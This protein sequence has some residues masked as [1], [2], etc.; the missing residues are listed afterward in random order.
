M[1]EYGW[2]DWIKVPA[3]KKLNLNNSKEAI[4]QFKIEKNRR[5]SIAIATINRFRG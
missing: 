3:N 2:K 5:D 4:R 1:M